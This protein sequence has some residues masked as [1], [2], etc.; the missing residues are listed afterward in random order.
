[1]VTQEEQSLLLAERSLAARIEAF[2]ARQEVA[3][4]RYTAAEAQVRIAET[5]AGVSDGV[6]QLGSALER[7]EAR[8]E[9]LRARAATL[10]GLLETGLEPGRAATPDPFERE[11]ACLDADRAVDAQL[12]ALRAQLALP[13]APAESAIDS[14]RSLSRPAV[15]RSDAAGP[16]A[17]D[18]PGGHP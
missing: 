16:L 14:P 15:D 8:T 3:S 12:S 5:L 10:D 2:R 7:T 11:L 13:A 9:Y 17:M 6:A 18:R 1:E 4:A